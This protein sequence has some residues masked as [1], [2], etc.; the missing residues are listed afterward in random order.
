LLQFLGDNFASFEATSRNTHSAT[1]LHENDAL[2]SQMAMRLT[3]LQEEM[4]EEQCRVSFQEQSSAN[5]RFRVGKKDNVDVLVDY[6][7]YDHTTA[8]A[9]RISEQRIA[10]ISKL[11]GEDKPSRFRILHGLG[12]LHE[13]LHGRRF[14]LVY[15]LPPGLS[16]KD[17]CTLAELIRAERTVPL[18]VRAKLSAAI[19]D[20]VL[21]IHSIGWYHKA[22]RSDNIL[23]LKRV[24]FGDGERGQ[25]EQYDRYDLEN[26]YLIGF[27]CSRPSD[28]DTWTAVDFSF[29]NNIYRHPDR[30]GRPRRFEK[31]HDIYALVSC[32]LPV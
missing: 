17:F 29:K 11:L 15:G 16:G 2:A 18:Q 6:W 32:P 25:F 9:F 8:E 21:N 28:A 23:I 13:T 30:W 7:Y 4:A 10:R 12:Y 27:D 19:C 20:A 24:G 1:I 14:G 3:L 22:I 26:P 31:H 5:Q